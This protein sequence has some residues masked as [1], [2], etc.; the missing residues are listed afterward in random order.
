[1]RSLIPMLC[2]AGLA[3]SGCGSDGVPE[4]RPVQLD[5]PRVTVVDA[6]DGDAATVRWR[7]E[8]AEQDASL[9]VTQGFTQRTNDG[10]ADSTTPDTRLE[11]PVSATVT[12]GGADR[13]VSL[14]LGKP[15][16]SNAELNDDIATA[17][18]FH[19]T[20]SGDD[21]GRIRELGMGAP[22]AATDTARAGIE[23][24]LM[25]WASLPLVFPE[26]PIGTGAKWTVVSLVGG[27]TDMRQTLTY[28]LVS[29]AGDELEL[30]VEVAQAPSVT[31]LDGG[32]GL[33]LRVV[34][35]DTDTRSGTL[36]V[37]LGKPLPV[38]GTIDYVTT[39]TYGD[40]EA[41]DRVVQQS[42]RAVQFN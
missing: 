23:S 6:G 34:G 13:T 39:V 4:T 7:D 10:A 33:T 19:V 22:E 5:A 35:S 27:G 12:G 28:T 18:G 14:D 40:G 41:D 2:A 8:G 36:R 38:G 15:F 37:N 26:E 42:H 24:G 31:E 20:W 17:E 32:D 29:R 16:G 21:T 3:L 1:M 25:Q 11:M 9:V 30:G